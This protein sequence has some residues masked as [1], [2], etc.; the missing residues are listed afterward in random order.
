MTEDTLLPFDLPAVNRKKVIAGFAGGSISS[1]GGFVAAA[2]AETSA[3]AARAAGSLYPGGGRPCCR[4]AAA[5]AAVG[6]AL[7]RD[8]LGLAHE[9]VDEQRDAG[10][11]WE[12]QAPLGDRRFLAAVVPTEHGEADYAGTR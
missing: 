4:F 8:D 12:H 10:S 11:A 3:C 7:D 9:A 6:I 2:R 5:A 1:D